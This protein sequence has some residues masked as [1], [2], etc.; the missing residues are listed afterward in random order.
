MPEL[1]AVEPA[2]VAGFVNPSS[3]RA[4]RKKKIEAE[5]AALAALMKGEEPEANEEEETPAEEQVVPEPEKE[6]AGTPEPQEPEPTSAEERTFKKRYGD[7]RKHTD[8]L[9][10]RIKELEDTKPSIVA[11]KSDEDIDE[12]L[13]QYPEVGSIVTSIAKREAQSLNSRFDKLEEERAEF[14]RKKAENK[15]REAHPDFDKLRDADDFHDWVEKQS[16]W[17]QDALY[18]NAD[19]PKAVISVID[20][21]KM[22]NGLTV[23]AKKAK[24]KEA[25]KAVESK[26]PA[27][28][29]TDEKPRYSES[30]I[31]RNSDSWFERNAQAIDEAIREGRFDYDLSGGAR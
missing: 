3:A 22:A 28:V 23:D 1:T 31:K 18:E 12:W 24:Q 25:A 9:K 14:S 16:R 27:K 5:E 26:A 21:Y 2:K 29:E 11:P 10:K 4:K 17:V 7:L 19:D 20:L 15:I 30:Q 13:K 6:E 8:D